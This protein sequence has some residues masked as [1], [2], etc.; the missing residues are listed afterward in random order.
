MKII[1]ERATHKDIDSIIH[2]LK[3]LYL[4][5]GEES[6]S[7]NFL[8]EEFLNHI[9]NSE[10]TE[11]FLA[12]TEGHILTGI[13]TITESQS[14]YAGGTYALLDEMYIKPEFRSSG[15]GFSFIDKIKDLGKQRN[16]KRIDV[17]APTEERWKRTVHFYEKCGFV[18]T[19]PK[20]KL[21]LL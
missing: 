9:L 12:K 21:N 5:L 1:V 7:V 10:Q 11:I 4:E 3:A 17:T 13:I 20:L 19:G 2:L 6:A 18:F 15:I 16:W 14:I 8:N